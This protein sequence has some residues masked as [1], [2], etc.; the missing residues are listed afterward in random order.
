MKTIEVVAAIITDGNL[1]SRQKLYV[2]P[3]Y[4]GLAAE[5]SSFHTL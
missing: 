2:L 4:Q 3:D 1:I 5:R